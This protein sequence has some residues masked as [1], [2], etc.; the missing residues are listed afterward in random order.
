MQEQ[1]QTNGTEVSKAMCRSLVTLF[2]ALSFIAFG[3]SLWHGFSMI[4]DPYLVRQNLA[5]HGPTFEH[6]QRIFTSYDPE[7]YIPLTLF[8]YQ[9]NYLIGGLDAGFYHFTNILIHGLN[10]ALVAWVLLLLTKKR[11][12]ALVA[13]LLW[14]VHPLNAEAVVWVAG[15][16]DLLSTFFALGSLC[17][18]LQY[19]ERG[20]RRQYWISLGMFALG[21]LCKATIFTLPAVFVLFD[22]A[23]EGREVQKEARKTVPFF[24]LGFVFLVIALLG[25]TQV[26]HASSL[27]ETVIMA[28]KSTAFY[29]QKLLM[30]TGLTVFYPWQKAITIFSPDFYLPWL[31]LVLLGIGTLLSLKKTRWGIVAALT[32]LILLAP[33]YFNFHKGSEIFFA[34]DRY[35]YLPSLGF[36]ILVAF[37]ADRLGTYAE[38]KM[39]YKTARNFSLG[40]SAVLI[41]LL[42]GLSIKQTAHWATDE[43]LLD[44]ALALY[45]DSGSARISLSV[46]Y[47]QEGRTDAEKKVLADGLAQMPT[48]AYYTGLG[49]I[50][51]RQNDFS[52]A[53]KNYDLGRALDPKNPEP[54]FYVGSL[55][56]QRGDVD[57]AIRDYKAAVALDPSYV[58]AY[59]NLGGVYQDQRKYAQAE[60]QFKLALT[61]N[62]Y[63]MEGQYNL[64][65]ILM[66]EH[67]DAEAI[68][69][70]VKAYELNPD[71]S[72]IAISYAY[73]LSVTGKKAEAKAALERMLKV[74]PNDAQAKHMLESLSAIR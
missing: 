62:P 8:S 6:L 40:V 28:G 39:F 35:A 69:H 2:V 37:A 60:E 32:Y 45:P 16:K 61:H 7:L 46:V 55:E 19:R 52:E 5:T 22:F 43:T 13:G 21:L 36:F 26:V 44:H 64:F 48:V 67:K 72:D 24:A 18:F 9:L 74:D 63:F 50:A 25:K 27:T 17:A 10:G 66:L 3:A 73:N 20:D 15:R 23:R 51:A 33:T 31:E 38:E 70:L 14:L 12:A 54:L 68:P 1:A 53:E 41:T 59:N 42:A 30:P 34:V 11:K 65:Q 56:E 47:R 49:S 58:A 4:D 57:A 71:S 29:L